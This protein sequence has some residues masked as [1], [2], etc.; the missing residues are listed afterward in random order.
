MFYVAI[1]GQGIASQPGYVRVI[2]MLCRDSVT[3]RCVMIEKAM[4]V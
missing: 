4:H 3:P 2:E 1:V